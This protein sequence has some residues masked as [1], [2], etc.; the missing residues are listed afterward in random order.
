[1]R[2]RSIAGELT[3]VSA[4]AVIM[5]VMT[6]CERQ[7]QTQ[8]VAKSQ[9]AKSEAGRAATSRSVSV[10]VAWAKPTMTRAA[11]VSPA[12]TAADGPFRVGPDVTAPKVIKRVAPRYPDL[13]GEYRTGSLVVECVIT[14]RGTVRD[15]KILK[16]PNNAFARANIAALEQWHFEPGRRHGQPVDVIYN[17]T[18][19]HVPYERVLS[20]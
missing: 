17:F 14:R 7:T 19:N 16:G 1:M 8:S 11:Q 10:P 15:V 20:E 3:R 6:G 5:L 4:L 18:V 2:A 12:D 13:V 9:P